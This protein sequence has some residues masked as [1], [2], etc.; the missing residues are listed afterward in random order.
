MIIL[1]LDD[2]SASKFSESILMIESVAFRI[3]AKK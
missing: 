3:I 1:I 2:F